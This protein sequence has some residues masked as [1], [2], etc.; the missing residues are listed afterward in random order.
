[1][2]A[3]SEFF[4]N[5]RSNVVQLELFELTHPAF[6]QPYRIV[7]NKRDG[8]VVDLSPTELGVAFTWYPANIRARGARDDLD[9]SIQIDLGDLGEVLPAELDAV[10]AAGAWLTKPVL[11][12]WTF[13]SDDLT[14]PLYGPIVLE[15]ASFNSNEE[16]TSFEARAP[17]LNTTKTGER[18]TLTRFPMLKGLL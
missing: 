18:Y 9:V 16:G 12:Y 11:R 8:V 10:D 2:S 15:A 7:R 4:L 5:S 13:R 6:T 3:A 1:M 14:A 17:L